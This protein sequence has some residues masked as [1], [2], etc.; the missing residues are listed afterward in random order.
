[1]QVISLIK[2]V[3]VY[4]YDS[5]AILIVAIDINKSDYKNTVFFF[6]ELVEITL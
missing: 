2:F 5:Y 6:V 3:N 4:L 1:M